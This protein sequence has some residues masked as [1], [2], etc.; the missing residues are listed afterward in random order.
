MTSKKYLSNK[1]T[2][3]QTISISPALKDWIERYV[4]VNHRKNPEDKRF[5]SISSFYNYVMEKSMESF[6]KGKTLDDF[7]RFV[8]SQTMNFFDQFTFKG[9]IPFHEMAIRSNRYTSFRFKQTPRFLFAIRRMFISG[10]RPKNYEELKNRFNRIKTFFLA[11]NLTKEMSLDIFTTKNSH[12]ANGV[13]EFIGTYKNL[14]LEN[15]KLNAAVFGVLGAK[16]TDVTF[17]DTELY[18]RFDLKETDLLF[19]NDIAKKE[20]F[21]LIE[22]NLSFLTNYYRILKD[23]T[24]YLWMKMAEDNDIIV[25]FSNK[26]A[27]EKWINLIQNE[28]KNYGTQEEF[29]FFLLRFFEKLHWISIENEK[30]LEFQIRLSETQNASERELLLEILSNYSKISQDNDRLYLEE[31]K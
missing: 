4:N 15:C 27:R 1:K 31:L 18:C 11:N 21:K 6:E 10:V 19:K 24:Y 14:F 26:N 7:E 13:F 20:R 25:N 5:N 28:I 22:H 17:S 3:Q 23:R 29:L 16:I 30:D 12:Y 8:D 2:A 9:I